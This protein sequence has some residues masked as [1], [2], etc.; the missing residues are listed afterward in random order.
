MEIQNKKVKFKSPNVEIRVNG[1]M[2]SRNSA[3]NSEIR[4]QLCDDR[5]KFEK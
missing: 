4:S 3:T 1:G 2:S 5:G